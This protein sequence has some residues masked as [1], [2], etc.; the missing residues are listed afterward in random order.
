MSVAAESWSPILDASE[1]AE[2]SRVQA[3]AP[4][5]L[6]AHPERWGIIRGRIRPIFGRLKLQAGVSNVAIGAGGALRI[7]MAR[8]HYEERGWT[9]LP[10][11]TLP[12]AQA[13][14]GSYLSRPAGRPDVTLCYWEECFAGSAALRCDEAL[15][16]EF[17]DHAA[18]LLPPPPL[19]V[20]ERLRDEAAQ[21]YATAA[22]RAQTMPSY[23]GVAKGAKE[24]LALVEHEIAA[25]G[26]T[27]VPAATAPVLLEDES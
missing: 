11:A 7:G 6:M 22:D 9:I 10:A 8:I 4:F 3:R 21:E 13:A 23:K 19:Y 12:P 24:R 26:A 14:R 15:H 17:L 25:R 27:A 5:L 18:T 1:R 16:D 20:L 2:V